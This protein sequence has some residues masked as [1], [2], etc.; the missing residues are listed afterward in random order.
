M[1]HIGPLSLPACSP[2]I[3][4]LSVDH[5]RML[6]KPSPGSASGP[7]LAHRGLGLDGVLES[8]ER[9]ARDCL[10]YPNILGQTRWPFLWHRAAR[11]RRGCGATSHT[12]LASGE[13]AG[14]QA[15]GTSGR[16]SEHWNVSGTSGWAR[17]REGQGDNCS[18]VRSL[19]H[20]QSTMGRG[21]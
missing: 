16:A 8:R 20:R 6:E 2:P 4:I 1:R 19:D 7:R 5:C 17:Y 12:L 13:A 15:Q 3:S 10:Q 18:R 14:G 9:G 11:R 21:D